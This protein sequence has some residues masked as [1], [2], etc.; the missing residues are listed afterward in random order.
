M[1]IIGAVLEGIGYPTPYRQSLPL[2]VG[3]L[4][5]DAPG[6]GEVL[7]RVEAAGLCHSDLSVINGSRIR[8]TPML[9]GHEAVARIEEV[10]D[11]VGDFGVG[12]R[13]V[14]TFM[15]R[16]GSC[17][18]CITEGVRPCVEGTATNTAGTLLGGHIRLHQDHTPVFH[19]LG[20][21]AFATHAVVNTRSLVKVPEDIPSD[22]AAVLGCAV[23]TGGGA[24]INVAKPSKGSTVVIVGLG[25]VGIAAALTALA[26]DGVEVIAVETAPSKLALASKLGIDVMT[27]DEILAAG[28]KAG[29][30]VDAT[31]VA[32]ALE[33][34]VSL[35]EAGGQTISVG[36]PAPDTLIS[37][38]PTSLVAEGRSLI[39]SY[40]GSAVPA[41]DIPIFI[42]MWRRGTL[43]LETMISHHVDLHDINAAMDSLSRAETLRQIITF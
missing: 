13:V 37:I 35:T 21:S 4:D 2:R 5:V 24:I 34:A 32:A 29:N 17:V 22:V 12:D 6:L 1:K 36:L 25:G 23:L 39:G 9:L 18:G 10:G 40:L 8:P 41:R 7:V 16:C 43:P 38:S 11:E 31:G 14:L 27:P 3:E 20:V 30:V 15:P 42:D 26:H 19:H 33:T 28:H